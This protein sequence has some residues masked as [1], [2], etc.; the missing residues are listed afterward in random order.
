MQSFWDHG[1][2]RLAVMKI[3]RRRWLYDH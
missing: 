3:L 2:N 1:D